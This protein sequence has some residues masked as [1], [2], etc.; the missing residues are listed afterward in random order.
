M[1]LKEVTDWLVLNEY[2]T[3]HKGKPIFTDKYRR[4]TSTPTGIATTTQSVALSP[5]V[6]YEE[7]Y[8]Q[9]ILK[10]DVPPRAMDNFGRPY[11][12]NKYSKDGAE[13]YKK[14][15]LKGYNPDVMVM[16]FYTY[17]K[18]P[19]AFK[20]AVGNYMTSGEWET[21]YTEFLAQHNQ[22]T[23]KTY[24]QKQTKDDNNIPW[25]TRG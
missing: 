25:V 21:D 2:M 22:G 18:S 19:V 10:A 13:A 5:A 23:L 17:Y 24:L 15:L 7:E 11:A 4:E 12:L 14:A 9:F 3:F 6:D 1:N 16:V 20:K 8:K